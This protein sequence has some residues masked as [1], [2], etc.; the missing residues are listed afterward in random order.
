MGF[1]PKLFVRALAVPTQAR[2]CT[3]TQ[4]AKPK[5][6]LDKKTDATVVRGFVSDASKKY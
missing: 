4:N 2:H 1:P 3:S 5:I 6:A